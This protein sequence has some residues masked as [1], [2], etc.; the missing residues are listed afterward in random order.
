MSLPR[1]AVSRQ[2][3]VRLTVSLSRQSSPSLCLCP[4]FLSGTPAVMVSVPE[5][6]AL[7][8]GRRPPWP[9]GLLCSAWSVGWLL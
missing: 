9:G 7:R 2:R 5:V 6:A 3:R 4:R 8:L 1:G